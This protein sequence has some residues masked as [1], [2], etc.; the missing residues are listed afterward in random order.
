MKSLREKI[1]RAILIDNLL[2]LE[3]K[4][5][6]RVSDLDLRKFYADNTS[7]ISEA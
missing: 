5:K 2:R 4:N 7:E 6:S 1:T 3:V